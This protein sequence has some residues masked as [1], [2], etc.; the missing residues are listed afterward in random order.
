MWIARAVATAYVE[1]FAN[2]FAARRNPAAEQA[3]A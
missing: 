3:A 1:S 2:A